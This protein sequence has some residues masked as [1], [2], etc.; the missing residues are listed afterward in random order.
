MSFKD[1]N[2]IDPLQEALDKE[3]YIEPT[4]IQALAIP[5]LLNGK[6]LMG[7]AQ[8]GTG[9][10]AAFVLPILQRLS[11]ERK[12]PVSRAPAYWCWPT[13]QR[14]GSP[15]RSELCHLRS[16]PA[17][18]AHRHL[19]RCGPRS[20]GQGSF[21]RCRYPRRYSRQAYRPDESGSFKPEEH[22]VLCAG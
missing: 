21:Q 12:A 6:D 1:L 5:H 19:R 4:P 22:R 16:F 20:P 14:A 3:G 9:K 2:I 15:D 18:Q 8:T 7:I 11:E 10:T 13:H 17:V